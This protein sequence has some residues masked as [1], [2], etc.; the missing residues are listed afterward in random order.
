MGQHW[1]SDVLA[2]YTLGFAYLVVL[3]EVYGRYRLDRTAAQ[4]PAEPPSSGR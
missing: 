1:A 4:A 2:S 3:I